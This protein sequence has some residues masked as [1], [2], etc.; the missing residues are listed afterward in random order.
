MEQL[1]NILFLLNLSLK[2]MLIQIQV[3]D[4]LIVNEQLQ[5]LSIHY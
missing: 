1:V 3:Y 2:H 4:S 5:V